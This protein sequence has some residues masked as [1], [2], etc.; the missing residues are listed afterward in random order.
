MEQ[1]PD[2]FP[3][4]LCQTK[5]PTTVTAK[6]KRANKHGEKQDDVCGSCG[7]EGGYIGCV[8]V[9]QAGEQERYPF[10]AQLQMR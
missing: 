10:R 1:S 2:L 8:G 5:S 3:E 4:D 7:D 6:A 9:D